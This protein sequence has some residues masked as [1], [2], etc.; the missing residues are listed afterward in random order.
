MGEKREGGASRASLELKPD[1]RQHHTGNAPVDMGRVGVEGGGEGGWMEAGLAE[2]PSGKPR[3]L[4]YL[5][6][7]LCPSPAF[8]E[9][10]TA[11][12]RRGLA[13]ERAQGE[14]G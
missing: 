8:E 1:T 3:G 11:T 4:R 13:R 5:L 12:P 14:C 2:A 7:L 10:F 6:C 9:P